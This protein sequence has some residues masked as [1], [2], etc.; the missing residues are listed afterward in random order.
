MQCAN[1]NNTISV[2]TVLKTYI[3]S[4]SEI[5]YNNCT[6]YQV[7]CSKFVKM[8]WAGS[9]IATKYTRLGNVCTDLVQP[10][11]FCYIVF[12]LVGHFLRE[13]IHSNVPWNGIKH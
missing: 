13:T 11:V 5:L 7:T 4:R 2:N 9:Y 10:K 6:I 3:I 1:K 12:L 8:M